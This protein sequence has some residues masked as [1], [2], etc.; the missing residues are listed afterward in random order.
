MNLLKPKNMVFLAS[1]LILTMQISFAQEGSLNINQ[2]PKIDK[3][4]AVKTSMNTSETD[5]ERYKIQV[6]SGNRQ[7]EAE[8]A[9]SIVK[10]KMSELPVITVFETPNYKVWVGNFRSRLE[11]DRALLKVQKEFKSA[12]VFKPKKEKD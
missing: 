6:F 4:L 1:C 8:K 7:A 5:S 2:D 9:K 12:F 11:A 3:L 10:T